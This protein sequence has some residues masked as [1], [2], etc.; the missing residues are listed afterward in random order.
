MSLDTLSNEQRD[1]LRRT[2]D[3]GLK[4]MQE[5]ADLKEGLRDTVKAVA[6][7]LEIKPALINAAISAAFKDSLSKQK[8]NLDTVEEILAVTGR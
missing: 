2:V 7:E 8:D 1:K 4:V 6:E 3:S 5:V